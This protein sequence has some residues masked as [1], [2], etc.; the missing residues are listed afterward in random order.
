MNN[1]HSG[2]EHEIFALF[3]H[4]FAIQ[5]RTAE[6]EAE[7][8]RSTYAILGL[9]DDEGPQRLGQIATAFRLDPSTITRQV[10]TAVRQGLAVKHTDPVDRRASILSLTDR[11]RARIQSVRAYRTEA[12][13]GVLTGWPEREQ[14]DLLRLLRRFNASIN[15]WLEA[16]AT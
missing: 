10:Q 3:R 12:L 9:L 14:K 13:A 15:G 8:D 2:I 11:G 16:Q 5:I 1:S 4:T 7:L 6:G